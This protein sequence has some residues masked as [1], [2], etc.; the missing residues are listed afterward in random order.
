MSKADKHRAEAERAGLEIIGPDPEGK[1]AYRLYRFK[2][3]GHMRR[4]TLHQVRQG[5]FFCHQCR[6]ERI[7]RQARQSGWEV[8][9]IPNDIANRQ[10]RC[11]ACGGLSERSVSQIMR[12]DMLCESCLVI[13]HTQEALA[14]GWRYLGPAKASERHKRMYVCMKCGT[15]RSINIGQ[16]RRRQA[17]CWVCFPR[18]GDIR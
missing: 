2:E 16:M 7:A 5:S 8:V 15:T 6:E 14:A 13:K 11:R 9:G 12:G 3:C 10:V 1:L 4:A 18:L 17:R